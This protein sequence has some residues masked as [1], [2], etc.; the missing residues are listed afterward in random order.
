MNEIWQDF[1]KR[2]PELS[3]VWDVLLGKQLPV[4]ERFTALSQDQ[5]REIQS[6]TAKLRKTDRSRVPMALLGVE[7]ITGSLLGGQPVK[8]DK[9]FCGSTERGKRTG[10]AAGITLIL[11]VGFMTLSFIS[12]GHWNAYLG[13]GCFL[14]GII[15]IMVGIWGTNRLVRKDLPPHLAETDYHTDRLYFLRGTCYLLCDKL[16][17]SYREEDRYESRDNECSSDHSDYLCVPIADISYVQGQM[18]ILSN[19]GA[20]S[21][22]NSPEL[23]DM[24]EYISAMVRWAPAPYHPSKDSGRSYIKRDKN[25]WLKL[26]IV[27]AVLLIGVYSMPSVVKVLQ[28][29][30]G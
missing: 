13:C 24:L 10:R 19:G 4:T 14:A 1:I 6:L 20:I 11:F 30:L 2:N 17:F 21:L 27:I 12:M 23:D 29:L 7:Q 25:A 3:W 8:Q 28:N 9:Y 16:F 18:L 22:Y 26:A 5:L 15:T